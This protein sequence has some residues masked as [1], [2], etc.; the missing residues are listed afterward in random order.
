MFF[1]PYRLRLAL[2]DQLGPFRQDLLLFSQTSILS[3]PPPLLPLPP[4]VKMM[5]E[6]LPMRNLRTIQKIK[7]SSYRQYRQASWS[8]PPTRLFARNESYRVT[9]DEFLLTTVSIAF[10]EA[11]VYRSHSIQG[12]RKCRLTRR[13]SNMFSRINGH[14][15]KTSRSKARRR[16][17]TQHF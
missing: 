12:S 9:Q 5:M 7:R 10:L 1:R 11:S 3:P 16:R 17:P 2:L 4:K 15:T 8:I 14:G 13:R 6:R